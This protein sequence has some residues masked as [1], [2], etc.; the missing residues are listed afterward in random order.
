[1]SR[2]GLWGEPVVVIS[3]GP[4][5]EQVVKYLLRNPTLGFH[6]V[7]FLSIGETSYRRSGLVP[8]LHVCEPDLKASQWP[9]Q[10]IHTAFLVTS[11]MPLNQE[12]RQL[13]EM[14]FNFSRLI[15]V[16]NVSHG[17]SLW[18]QTCDI[19]GMLGLEVRQNLLSTIQQTEK[20]ILDLL[21]VVCL[22]PLSIPLFGLI[23]L[24]IWLDSPG[25]IFYQQTR[26]GQYGKNIRVWKFRTMKANAEEELEKHL[27]KHPDL[28][29]EWITTRKLKNDPRIT[30]IGSVLRRISLDELPQIWNVIKG[31]MSLVG[32]RPIVDSEIIYYG[33]CFP[34]YLRVKPGMTGIWQVSGRNNVSYE[35]R[36]R[37]DEY[38]VRNWSIWLDVYILFKTIP[39]LITTSGAY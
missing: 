24:A 1:M 37:L 32:P 33:D 14:M 5:G 2:L 29:S 31:E 36:V 23:M 22:L 15:M 34:L 11:D 13:G 8:T 3:F 4:S 18:V 6:P 27:T 25:N 20:R 39:A 9:F 12:K 26:I 30:R 7:L 28:Y 21:L 38:Y 10:R 35:E 19:G 17:G 16:S